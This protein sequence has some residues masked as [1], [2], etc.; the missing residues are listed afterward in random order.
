MRPKLFP[1]PPSSFSTLAARLG[2]S[3]SWKEAVDRHR[4]SQEPGGRSKSNGLT[5]PCVSIPPM[6]C[7]WALPTALGLQLGLLLKNLWVVQWVWA[8]N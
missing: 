8:Q 6:L 5:E 3:F 1:L 7:P 4:L 2:V